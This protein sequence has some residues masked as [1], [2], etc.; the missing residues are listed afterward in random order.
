MRLRFIALMSVLFIAMYVGYQQIAAQNLVT[1]PGLVQQAIQA[2]GNNCGGLDRNS[3]CYG[4]SDVN[5]T[6]TVPQPV[7]YFSAPSDRA[8]LVDLQ[9]LNTSP[10]NQT[11]DSWGIALLSVQANLPDTLP[12]QSVVFM[13]L[14][15]TQ[16]ENAVASDQAFQTGATVNVTLQIGADLYFTADFNAQVV[17]SVPQGTALTSDA[18]SADGQWVRVVY[19]GVPGWITRQVL[20]TSGDLSTLPVIGP[21]TR[22]P[23]QAF[24]LR[25]SVSGTQC[26]QAPNA[27]VVQGPKNLM[28]DIN[29]N[30][31]DIRLGSTIVIYMIPVDPVTQ[32]YLTDQY[33]DIGM[34]TMLMQI[35]VLDG[36]VVLNEG[37]PDEIVLNTGETT[38]TCL[39][40]P[41]NLGTDGESN[42]R[43]VFNG[44]PWA[45][46]RPVTETDIEQFRYLDGVT[47][48]YP[49][50]LPLMLPTLTP[51]FTN[52]PRPYVYVAP[53]VTPVPPTATPTDTPQP[54]QPQQPQPPPP[55][56]ATP[57]PSCPTVP[58]PANDVAALI[59][60]ITAANV[61]PD[62]NTIDL[63]GES[64]YIVPR[65]E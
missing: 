33:G 63:A 16:I 50:D 56:T 35:V 42:D 53:T 43:Q 28:V 54:Q 9:D 62:A 23:M 36:H 57:T 7:S 25:T 2:V 8:G 60:A 3:A 48:N 32:Q 10:M 29:A 47:L 38:F 49:I 37:T 26:A 20:T 65:C 18:I 51:T 5:A 17:G 21:D 30:G 59:A 6:F 34:V 46:P 14:G 1:C 55:P 15:D 22:T 24:Y 31:A 4:F 40:N 64:D 19:R 45:P 11:L 27:L 41:E 39:S 61:C 12:G 13:L 58:S 44:C 52:T